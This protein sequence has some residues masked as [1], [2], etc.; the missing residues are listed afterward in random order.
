MTF[1][2]F[3]SARQASQKGGGEAGMI[4]LNYQ[5]TFLLL[6]KHAAVTGQSC[7]SFS[8]PHRRE[9]KIGSIMF[10]HPTETLLLPGHVYNIWTIRPCLSCH[11]GCPTRH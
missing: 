4:F 5:Q 7:R 3:A 2:V 9:G 1:L 6:I 11:Y 8:L 10:S